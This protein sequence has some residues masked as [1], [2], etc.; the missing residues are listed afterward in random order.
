MARQQADRKN[1]SHP[2][3]LRVDAAAGS[4]R[5]EESLALG[6]QCGPQLIM[7]K[8]QKSK[9]RVNLEGS[10]KGKIL[11]TEEQGEEVHLVLFR[12]QETREKWDKEFKLLQE[13]TNNL[14]FYTL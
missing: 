4:R 12:N 1:H 11:L 6:T 14:D 8:L 13:K 9:P 3:R 7:G 5:G 2:Q 10:Q